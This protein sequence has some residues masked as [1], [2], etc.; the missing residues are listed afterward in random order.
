MKNVQIW[1]RILNIDAWLVWKRIFIMWYQSHSVYCVR[2]NYIYIPQWLK[3]FYY[4]WLI[5]MNVYARNQIFW[6]SCL[7]RKYGSV[8][9]SDKLTGKAVVS[10]NNDKNSAWS[11]FTQLEK[12]FN[13]WYQFWYLDFVKIILE[14][15]SFLAYKKHASHNQWV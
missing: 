11:F 1:S 14:I 13:V 5:L 9:I 4:L 12:I 7:I 6:K 15:A 3:M 8:T 10:Y 2:I